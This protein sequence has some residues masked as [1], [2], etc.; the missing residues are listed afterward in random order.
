MWQTCIAHD[1][2]TIIYTQNAKPLKKQNSLSI[3]NCLQKLF[4]FIVVNYIYY[5]STQQCS[6]KTCA[7]CCATFHLTHQLHSTR[8]ISPTPIRC[9]LGNPRLPSIVGPYFHHPENQI[10][11]QNRLIVSF[12]YRFGR[13]TCIELNTFRNCIPSSIRCKP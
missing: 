5:P 7:Q 10:Q 3:C 9:N 2:C 8:T 1:Q 11:K 4:H 13:I 6:S 12:L